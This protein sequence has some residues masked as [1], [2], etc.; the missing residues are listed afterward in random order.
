MS[1]KLN[2]LAADAK[3]AE[4]GGQPFMQPEVPKPKNKG[5]R[6]PWTEEQKQAARDRAANQKAKAAGGA[7]ASPGAA[8]GGSAGNQG[9]AK[10]NAFPPGMISKPIAVFISNVGVNYAKDP[11]AQMTPAEL[12]AIAAGFDAVM[13]KYFP[14][15]F[16]KYP[17]EAMLCVA[18]GGYGIRITA[19]KKV[20]D[21]ERAQATVQKD[22][23]NP[24]RAVQTD[25]HDTFK[26]GSS[27][28]GGAKVANNFTTGEENP[29][30]GP[31][32]QN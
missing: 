16:E 26:A 18:L 25:T 20:L 1:D 8:A 31:R 19:M 24:P 7:S 9:A 22:M 28:T 23:T 21:M 30:N 4:T 5:G 29:F 2:S 15:L 27:G 14:M 17:Q 32:I 13:E 11:R 6:P 10:E 12:E 3:L